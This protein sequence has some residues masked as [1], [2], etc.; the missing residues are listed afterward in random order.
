MRTANAGF[1][2]PTATRLSRI[3]HQPGCPIFATASSSLRWDI[4][5]GSKRPLSSTQPQPL[6]CPTLGAFAKV[7]M[8][9]N[10]THL[11]FAL[12][13]PLPVLLRTPKKPSSR[14]ERSG[15]ER[16]PHFAFA[17][18]LTFAFVF[19]SPLNADSQIA[20]VY[21]PIPPPQTIF[22]AFTQQNRMSSPQ[23]PQKPVTHS[24]QT[25]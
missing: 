23:H 20:F 22:H 25:R 8:Y 14:P 12:P 9:K 7:G 6:G 15:V 2:S 18:A 19:S 10:S 5:C 11:V 16:P 24:I 21:A 3:H 1:L 4:V 17:L 13:S